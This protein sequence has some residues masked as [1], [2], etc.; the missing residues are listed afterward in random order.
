VEQADPLNKL[1]EEDALI[2][3]TW[4]RYFDTNGTDPRVLLR[5]PMTKVAIN[6]ME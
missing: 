1:R 3:W 5:F 6:H 2:A 4:K